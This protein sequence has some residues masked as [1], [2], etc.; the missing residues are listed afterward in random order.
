MI[1]FRIH[2]FDLL[3]AQRILNSLLQHHNL[4]VSIF[5]L[6][7]HWEQWVWGRAGRTEENSEYG[8]LV[9][10]WDEWKLEVLTVE[11]MVS[12]FLF[13]QEVGR[14]ESLWVAREVEMKS[15]NKLDSS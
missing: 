5:L 4:K 6:W 14:I 9:M 12:Y 15:E 3:A 1:S 7:D 2:W 8:A 10:S 13:N 11:S